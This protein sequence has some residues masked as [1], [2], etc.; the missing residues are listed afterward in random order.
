MLDSQKHHIR[1][2][3]RPVEKKKFPILEGDQKE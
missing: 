2:K 3:G 1:C